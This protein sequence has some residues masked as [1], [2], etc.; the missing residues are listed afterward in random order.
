LDRG[1]VPGGLIGLA[2]GSTDDI[3]NQLVAVG[4]SEKSPH[5]V[6][7]GRVIDEGPE[8]AGTIIDLGD[9]LI[10]VLESLP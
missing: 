3:S 8:G 1:L 6:V 10:E 5:V 9:D 2:D 7:K 4:T